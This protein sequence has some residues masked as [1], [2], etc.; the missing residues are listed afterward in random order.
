MWLVVIPQMAYEHY[1]KGRVT[2]DVVR[3]ELL[4]DT[5]NLQF[6]LRNM[7]RSPILATCPEEPTAVAPGSGVLCMCLACVTT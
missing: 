4:S 6:P 7:R 5:L 1:L 2:A 3:Q